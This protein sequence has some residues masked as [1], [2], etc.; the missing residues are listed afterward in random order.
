MF[1]N[2][3][4]SDLVDPRNRNQDNC[5]LPLDELNALKDLINLQK[6][7]K[8]VVKACDK[9]AGIIILDFN[10]YVK[11]CYEHLIS[12]TTDGQPYYLQVNE[13]DIEKAKNEIDN[14]LKE[15]LEN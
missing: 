12:K 4:K 11:A 8:I 2:A 1:L 15:G 14:L 13:L 6:D 3:V 7:R 9:G 10:D 5:N